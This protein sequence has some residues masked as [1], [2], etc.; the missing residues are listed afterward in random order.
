MAFRSVLSLSLSLNSCLVCQ[1]TTAVANGLPEFPS[2]ACLRLPPL[3][4]RASRG[5]QCLGFALPNQRLAPPAASLARW[6]AAVPTVY[7]LG[8]FEPPSSA[9][10]VFSPGMC[11]AGRGA[12]GR[13]SRTAHALLRSGQTRL[14]PV[15]RGGPPARRGPPGLGRVRL[16]L[17]FAWCLLACVTEQRW[18]AVQ[19]G[20]W[21]TPLPR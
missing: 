7:F 19:A 3:R 5:P 2:Q 20:P 17:G 12:A 15:S 11:C 10:A 4:P 18:V 9:R 14:A 1:C 6:P 8:R 13:A 16:E 21:G